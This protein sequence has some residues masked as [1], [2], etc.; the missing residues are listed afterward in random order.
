KQKQSHRK[1]AGHRRTEGQPAA[2]EAGDGKSPY[3]D[4]RTR[5]KSTGQGD[6]RGSGASSGRKQNSGR[7]RNQKRQGRKSS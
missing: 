4:I 2:S 3:P 7:T 1:P 6:R 5:R